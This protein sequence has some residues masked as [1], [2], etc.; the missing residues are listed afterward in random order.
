MNST[1][2]Q[3]HRK[4]LAVGVA[5]LGVGGVLAFQ[6]YMKAGASGTPEQYLKTVNT[7]N[8][9]ADEATI[10]TSNTFD[11]GDAFTSINGLVNGAEMKYDDAHAVGSGKSLRISTGTTAATPYVSWSSAA[12]GTQPQLHESVYVWFDS[13]PTTTIRLMEFRDSASNRN[14]NVDIVGG[15]GFVRTTGNSGTSATSTT[16]IATG[17]WI[18]IDAKVVAN[19]TAG[20]V[21]AKLFN[22][23]SSSIPTATVTKTGVPTLGDVAGIRLGIVTAGVANA[24]PFW[25]DNPRVRVDDYPGAYS[26][27]AGVV[28]INEAFDNSSVGHFNKGGNV[29]YETATP[30]EG[31]ASLH[32]NATTAASWAEMTQANHGTDKRFAYTSFKWRYN[33]SATPASNQPVVNVRN[34]SDIAFNGGGHLNIWFD[35]VTKTFKGDLQSA[36]AF[37]SAVT[38]NPGQTYKFEILTSFKDDGTSVAKVRIDGVIVADIASTTPGSDWFRS[39][40]L[41]SNVANADYNADYDNVTVVSSATPIDMF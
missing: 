19:A 1:Y 41:G 13:I 8:N 37:T 27:P 6:G 22:T 33:G 2:L 26:E 25:I 7:F 30:L 17:Q 28:A 20:T 11:S 14:G 4:Q 40:V 23:A 24:G 31:A 16:A 35:S 38:V 34:T 21:E 3:D 18:R 9:S 5:I 39:V 29:A 10:T 36:N 32:L 15:T 12:L